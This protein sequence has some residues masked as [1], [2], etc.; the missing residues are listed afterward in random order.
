MIDAPRLR[1]RA[2]T[3]L[4]AR[5][6]SLGTVILLD[7]DARQ[8]V[9]DGV[10]PDLG[11]VRPRDVDSDTGPLDDVGG[12]HVLGRNLIENRDR[13]VDEVVAHDL[14]VDDSLVEP[15]AN[16]MIRAVVLRQGCVLVQIRVVD[17]VVGETDAL[18]VRD[19]GVPEGAVGAAGGGDETRG[20]VRRPPVVFNGDVAG[21]VDPEAARAV[22]LE[23]IPADRRILR[24]GDTKG[25]GRRGVAEGRVLDHKIVGRGEHHGT[26]R[27]KLDLGVVV[28]P[29]LHRRV[30]LDR[31]PLER[32]P[33]RRDGQ[34]SR[35]LNHLHR[36]LG[37]IDTDD[38]GGAG[39]RFDVVAAPAVA[40]FLE[41][42]GVGVI[43]EEAGRRHLVP[44]CDL[45]EGLAVH[46]HLFGIGGHTL[47]GRVGVGGADIAEPHH[48]V[49]GRPGAVTGVL[50]RGGVLRTRDHGL[51][52]GRGGDGH[53][54][55][56]VQLALL[57]NTVGE[58]DRVT[59]GSLR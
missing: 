28:I 40:G 11:A 56:D 13:H 17:D 48:V 21:F 19:L 6:A 5:V 1:S 44:R 36:V 20:V 52:P 14:G 50:P 12:D 9:R 45:G 8:R 23:D 25:R 58:L 39:V 4:V 46:E 54:F 3:I 34:G 43:D 55:V 51:G 15:N 53:L 38:V 49:G 16:P 27:E 7:E 47:D 32:G 35:V 10:V 37:G 22:V 59:G 18:R 26:A 33:S 2:G 29:F 41:R 31:H 57:V 24:V 42:D 30:L